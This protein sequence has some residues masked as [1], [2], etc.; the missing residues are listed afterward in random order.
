MERPYEIRRAATLMDATFDAKWA[1]RESVGP[2]ARRLLALILRSF[3]EDGG[4]VNIGTL[5]GAGS[6]DERHRAVAELDAHD[7]ILVESGLVVLAYPFAGRPTGFVTVLPGG[8]ERHACC[9]VDALGIPAMLGVP[10]TIRARC[11][12][13]GDPLEFEVAPTGPPAGSE[14]MVWIGDRED[15]R[16][17]ACTSL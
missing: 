5:S 2:Q 14:L 10:A 8:R 6:E 16:A 4:P 1:V 12:D 3:V 13:C 7:L 17:K 9:A 11:H 15:L